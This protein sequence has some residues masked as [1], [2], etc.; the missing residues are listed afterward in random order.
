MSRK[1]SMGLSKTSA[2]AGVTIERAGEVLMFTLDNVEHG[3]EVT[4]AMF[5][6]MLAELRAEARKPIARWSKALIAVIY[7][8]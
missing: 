4:G 2:Q 3:N 7:Q 8:A 6:A 5:D 1:K